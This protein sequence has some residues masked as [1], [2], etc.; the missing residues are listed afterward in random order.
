M[1]AKLFIFL[2]GI[3]LIA[4]VLASQ[5]IFLKPIEEGNFKQPNRNINYEFRF[6]QNSDCSGLIFSNTSSVRTNADG[7]AVFVVEVPDYANLTSAQYICEYR[8]GRFIKSSTFADVFFNRVITSSINVKGNVT[9]DSFQG[10]GGNLTGIPTN[11]T[12]SQIGNSTY[13][14]NTTFG[15]QI[16]NNN[17]NSSA[18]W[19]NLNSFNATQ[20]SE[21]NGLLNILESYLTTFI[22]T[23]NFGANTTANIQQLLIGTNISQFAFNQTLQTFNTYNSTWDNRALITGFAKNTTAEFQQSLNNTNM[24]FSSLGIG[25]AS[26][27]GN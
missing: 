22:N 13:A 21:S 5:T 11:L 14:Q 3:F 18:Y 17:S 19:D 26:P 25:T 24:Y 23:F 16:L 15:I 2:L 6:S 12:I 10:Y 1:R 7:E 4:N 27:N 9:A 20:M 8:D